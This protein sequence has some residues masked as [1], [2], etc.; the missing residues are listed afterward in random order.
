MDVFSPIRFVKGII[1]LFVAISDTLCSEKDLLFTPRL[2]NSYAK[3][4]ALFFWKAIPIVRSSVCIFQSCICT[5]AIDFGASSLCDVSRVPAG[6]PCRLTRGGV[7][8]RHPSAAA[9]FRPERVESPCASRASSQHCS[10]FSC[11]RWCSTPITINTNPTKWTGRR[12][13]LPHTSAQHIHTITAAHARSPAIANY[14]PA[15][16]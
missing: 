5:I 1:S 13:I 15:W 3:V 16:E 12:F 11:C 9:A 7:S 6:T 4:I 14:C 2:F 10:S 8:T